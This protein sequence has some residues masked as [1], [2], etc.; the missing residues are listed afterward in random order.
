MFPFFLLVLFSLVVLRT[1]NR[2]DELTHREYDVP[3]HW[4][5]MRFTGRTISALVGDFYTKVPFS[6]YVDGMS[7]SL[8]NVT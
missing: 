4:Q 2:I 8:V 6:L 7:P 1:A 3:F 5:R